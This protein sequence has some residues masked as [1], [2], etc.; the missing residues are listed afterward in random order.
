MIKLLFVISSFIFINNSGES[1]VNVNL[2]E[3]NLAQNKYAVIATTKGGLGQEYSINLRVTASCIGNSCSISKVEV[4]GSYG[5]SSV[6]WS[7]D[8]NGG[9]YVNYNGRQYYFSF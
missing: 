8:F 7:S 1:N 5:Y 6:S 9:Y 4:A 3:A 2:I